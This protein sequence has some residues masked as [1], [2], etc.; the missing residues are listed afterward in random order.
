M[1][2]YYKGYLTDEDETV[3]EDTGFDAVTIDLSNTIEGWQIAVPMLKPGGRGLFL[4]PSELGY[5]SSATS[6]IPKNSV[7]IFNINLVAFYEKS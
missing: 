3:F 5:G 2:V 1:V 4:I 6:V 7:L